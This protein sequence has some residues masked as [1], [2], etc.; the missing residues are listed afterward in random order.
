MGYSSCLQWLVFFKS[1]K[2]DFVKKPLIIN[3]FKFKNITMF[4][5]DSKI[6]DS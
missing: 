5:K 4:D 2:V 3:I 6:I 1:R